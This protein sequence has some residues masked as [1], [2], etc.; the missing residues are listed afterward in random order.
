MDAGNIIEKIYAFISYYEREFELDFSK[1]KQW[2]LSITDNT[3]I[4]KAY[5]KAQVMYEKFHYDNW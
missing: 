4:K 5:E 3:I 2:I 1:T